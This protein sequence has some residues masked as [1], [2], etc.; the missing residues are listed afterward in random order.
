MYTLFGDTSEQTEQEKGPVSTA[1]QELSMQPPAKRRAAK[2]CGPA[3]E[4]HG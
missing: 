3:R 4:E 1:S 2:E